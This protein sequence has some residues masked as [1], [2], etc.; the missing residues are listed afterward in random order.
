MLSSKLGRALSAWP[1]SIV[2]LSALRVTHLHHREASIAVPVFVGS[3]AALWE[4]NL[5]GCKALAAFSIQNVLFID[6]HA[7]DLHV[8]MGTVGFKATDTSTALVMDKLGLPAKFVEEYML[9]A[10]KRYCGFILTD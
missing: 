6:I 1:E 4:L 3:V 2:N 7:V 9:L 8:F 5:C 10:L